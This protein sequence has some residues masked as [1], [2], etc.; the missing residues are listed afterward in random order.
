MKELVLHAGAYLG[1]PVA[2]WSMRKLKQV[3]AEH[4]AALA[5]GKG[6]KAGKPAKAAKGAKG[7][8]EVKPAKAAKAS[9]SGKP[10]ETAAKGKAKAKSK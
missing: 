3:Q 6:G 8:K 7:A 5:A 1:T 2:M 4:E 9:K 10:A